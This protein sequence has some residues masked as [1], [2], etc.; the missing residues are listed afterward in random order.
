MC[1]PST[2]Y[3]MTSVLINKL[4]IILNLEMLESQWV[5][6]LFVVF[7]RSITFEVK[8]NIFVFMIKIYFRPF[9]A[10]HLIEQ[11]FNFLALVEKTCGSKCKLPLLFYFFTF[12][13]VR[14]VNSPFSL[15]LRS[16]VLLL[17]HLQL[18]L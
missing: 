3:S 17:T 6:H 12:L 1:R 7:F 16:F 13:I 10:V 8:I 9:N 4:N 2:D 18:F 14:D 15:L 11:L 5:L